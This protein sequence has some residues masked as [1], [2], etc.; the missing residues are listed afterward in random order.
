M[1]NY[2]LCL[3]TLLQERKHEYF[4]SHIRAHSLL[5]EFLAEGNAHADKLAMLISNTFPDIFE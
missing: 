2:L 4:V 5:S 3:R 1:K